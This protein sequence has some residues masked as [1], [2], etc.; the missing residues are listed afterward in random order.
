[1]IEIMADLHKYVPTKTT[2]ESYHNQATGECEEYPQDKYHEI[3]LGGD[4]LT[5]ARARSSQ[6]IRMN[7][8]RQSEALLGLVPCCEDWH[9]K[10]TLL[11]VS[12][13]KNKC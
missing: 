10:V 7:S 13:H 1:M 12:T 6:T 4:Q 11:T 2:T 5:C 9:V 8:D 3:L